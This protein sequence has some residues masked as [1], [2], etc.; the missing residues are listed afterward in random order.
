MRSTVGIC[1]TPVPT[2]LMMA[3][4]LLGGLFGLTPAEAACRAGRDHRSC[5]VWER[6]NVPCDPG[7]ELTGVIG[8]TC[9]ALG[10]DVA[11]SVR[12]LPPP[13]PPTLPPVRDGT[14]DIGRA[15]APQR[16][17][18][19]GILGCIELGERMD[20][21]RAVAA[22]RA[23]E[24]YVSE[25]D[26]RAPS[27]PLEGSGSD[28]ADGDVFRAIGIGADLSVG[29]SQ[30]IVLSVKA[31]VEEITYGHAGAFSVGGAFGI[32]FDG[33]LPLQRRTGPPSAFQGFTIGGSIGMGIDIG[34]G[35]RETVTIW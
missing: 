1:R 13:A 23:T 8:G 17:A 29:S 18:A 20:S 14:I 28:E 12:P 15:T 9:R 21:S 22:T 4:R 5:T 2:V 16:A 34:P 7:R 25:D 10:G 35:Q 6:W 26:R 31:I 24:D 3:G 32:V 11:P 30:D 33:H 19:A 27:R